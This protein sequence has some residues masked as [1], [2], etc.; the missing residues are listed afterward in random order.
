LS[1]PYQQRALWLDR[2][3][4]DDKTLHAR[5]EALL[6]AHEKTGDTLAEPMPA[7]KGTMKIE[8]AD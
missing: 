2:E 1:K 6:A 4:G 3:C 7:D 8:F 5:I